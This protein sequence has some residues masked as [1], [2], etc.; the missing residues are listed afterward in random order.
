MGLKPI[1]KRKREVNEIKGIAPYGRPAVEPPK[2]EKGE[3]VEVSKLTYVLGPGNWGQKYTFEGELS[4]GYKVRA[5]AKY[6]EQPIERA[7]IYQICA[8]ID[9]T[10]GEY[11]N[12]IDEALA[13]LIAYGK[14]F[15]ECTGHREYQE[16]MY[17]TFTIR[18]DKLPGA[19]PVPTKI[20]QPPAEPV[21]EPSGAQKVIDYIL[22]VRPNLDAET[23][24]DLI[25]GSIYKSQGNLNKHGAAVKVAGDLGIDLETSGLK[26]A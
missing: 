2:I 11:S 19:K 6:Y 24:N 23:L 1:E 12:S 16:R 17:P 25:D 5:F 14:A 18:T 21:V 22:T 15:Y 20:D 9:K 26:L 13:R 10:Y 4:S 8:L 7:K 3:I